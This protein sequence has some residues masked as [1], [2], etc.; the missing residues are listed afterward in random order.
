MTLAAFLESRRAL[1]EAAL[2]AMLPSAAPA[3]IDAAMRY[4]LLGGG[5]RL[6]PLLVLASYHMVVGHF[7]IAPF[8]RELTGQDLLDP[9]SL[10][11]WTSFLGDVFDLWFSAPQAPPS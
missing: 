8:Y 1:V 10:A 11:R 2:P 7:A 9:D 5:K 3:V 4:S 6:R